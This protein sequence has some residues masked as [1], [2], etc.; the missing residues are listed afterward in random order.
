METEVPMMMWWHILMLPCA[1][2]PTEDEGDKTK[3]TS[4]S[5]APDSLGFIRYREG[6]FY[7]VTYLSRMV[8]S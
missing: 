7:Q 4:R 8:Q 5:A 2:N 6:D 1:G 3:Y